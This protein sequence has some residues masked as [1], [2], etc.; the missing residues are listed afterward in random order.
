M[1]KNSKNKIFLI[2]LLISLSG[3]STTFI[4]NSLRN[5]ST[6]NIHDTSR[7]TFEKLPHNSQ[8]LAW[9]VNGK[10][11]C[12]GSQDQTD[13]QICHDGNDGIFVVWDE[14]RI[15]VNE[16]NIYAQHLDSNGI[17]QWE[18]NGKEI[19]TENLKQIHPL[20][21]PDGFGGAI[22]VWLD[23]RDGLSDY[24]IYAQRID[25]NGITQWNNNGTLICNAN[26]DQWDVQICSDGNGGAIITWFDP[27]SSNGDIYAQRIASNG[28]VL[29]DLNGTLLCTDVNDQYRPKICSDGSG[30]AIIAWEDNRNGAYDIYAQHIASNGLV[31]WGSKGI[32]VCIAADYQQYPQIC[33]DGSGGA[34][35][36][37]EDER[38]GDIDIYAQHIAS[39]GVAQWLTNGKA[40]STEIYDQEAL[41]IYSDR[42][43]GA[44]IVWQDWRAGSYLDIYAQH[45]ASNGVPQWLI[46][47]LAVCTAPESQWEPQICGDGGGGA[48][49][50][51][52]DHRSGSQY[53]IYAQ[54]VD[55]NGSTSWTSNGIAICTDINGQYYPQI[56][57]EG[58]GTTIIVWEDYRH[59]NKDLYAQKVENPPPT[60]NH[61]PNIITSIGGT[62]TINWSLSDDFGTGNYRVLA[63]YT[64][65]NNY[66]WIDWTSWANN[67]VLHVPINRTAL[68][69]FEYTIQYYDDQHNYGTSDTVIVQILESEGGI[70]GY[71]LIILLS[72]SFGLI[73]VIAKRLKR[74]KTR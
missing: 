31:Q 19:C 52:W 27:R 47:G 1:K 56:S 10:E 21:I 46:N 34:I 69:N 11:V 62:E 50:T 3:I 64:N 42:A 71:S 41:Q 5:L 6:M 25:S 58:A 4:S 13:F 23:T 53:D 14:W 35:I 40:V 37:W 15:N 9:N 2:V 67:T 16:Y 59:G 74:V 51:W 48:I 12:V 32:E 63:N 30:G 70:S 44:I 33:R 29:W 17:L 22:I 61:P 65:G 24:D 49:I 36:A 55:L 43:G 26:G 68:G 60:S 7:I 28:T 54:R 57:T 18:V 45:I 66:I 38:N 20:I 8:V 73:L 39:N 72:C